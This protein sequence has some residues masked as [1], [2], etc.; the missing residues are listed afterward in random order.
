[1]KVTAHFLTDLLL[2]S[3]TKQQESLAAFFAINGVVQQMDDVPSCFS[4]QDFL[5]GFLQVF[6]GIPY[7]SPPVGDLRFRPPEDA[8]PWSGTL[9][10][11]QLGPACLQSP[12]DLP[13]GINRM[14]EDCL[15]LNV[16]TPNRA[17]NSSRSLPV[18]VYIHHGSLQSGASGAND[19]KNLAAYGQVVVVEIN[20]RLGPLGFLSTLDVN[21]P[22]NLGFLDMT[23]GLQWIRH[24]IRDFGGDPSC[25]T[26][27]GHG[28]GG[29]AVSYLLLSPLT[30][31]LFH[32]AIS[33]SGNALVPGFIAKPGDHYSDPLSASR[34][35]AKA[36]DC[37]TDNNVKMVD[38][39]RTKP[40][41]SLLD[42]PAPKPKHGVKF[43]PVVDGNFLQ[44]P[45]QDT[46]L[47]GNYM[48]VPYIV[49]LTSQE[50][51]AEL[52]NL[53][54]NGYGI[55]TGT[56]HKMVRNYISSHFR[57]NPSQ[58]VDVTSYSYR[59]FTHPNDPAALR[60]GF[61]DLVQDHKWLAPTYQ[62]A[63][64]HSSRA[65]TFLYIY[66]YPPS[67]SQNRPWIGAS[68]LDDLLYLLGDPVGK[69]PT[70]QYNE[71]DK[72]LSFSL[73]TYWTNFAHSGNPNRG[74]HRILSWPNY[75][76]T[77]TEFMNFTADK[78]GRIGRSYRR[79]QTAFWSKTALK[80]QSEEWCN[81]DK[82]SPPPVS[83]T[84]TA[85]PTTTQSTAQCNEVTQ[86]ILAMNLT[87]EE[88]ITAFYVSFALLFIEAFLILGLLYKLYIQQ[89]KVRKLQDPLVLS[90]MF[91]VP[92]KGATNKN[93]HLT[94][95]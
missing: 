3:S 91:E 25:I 53:L 89:K 60:E 84:T 70:H 43:P 88:I 51:G 6:L 90:N 12:T 83:N 18:M 92:F 17:G 62:L 64:L 63:D 20:Y 93:S 19:M 79:Q 54:G 4:I 45:P 82:E 49:G 56:Y 72:Q 80:M 86:D 94:K 65:D 11:T 52:A 47:K 10:A 24:N 59:D 76:A 34:Q 41:E 46:F 40:A 39:L 16:Y 73:M 14:S 48:K 22:G 71:E 35:L 26:L 7:A 58:I 36:L 2:A 50:A 9:D 85:R 28:A 78:S 95:F 21:A 38:C 57:Y 68:H 33:S 32:R 55:D 8:Q 27:F 75:T 1:M 81:I 69:N 31:G 37:P 77:D 15:Y 66:S 23:K 67:F 5:G 44:E 29:L 13:D 61:T 42:A 74:P 87:A 30:T